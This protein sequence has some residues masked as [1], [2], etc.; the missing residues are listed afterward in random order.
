MCVQMSTDG[1]GHLQRNR[2]RPDAAVDAGD[3]ICAQAAVD[4]RPCAV[5]DRQVAE[6]RRR[7]TKHHFRQTDQE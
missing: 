7:K 1:G 4:D 3:R 6:A 5:T 2:R